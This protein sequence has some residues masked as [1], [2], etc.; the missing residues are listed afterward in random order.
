MGLPGATAYRSPRRWFN[1]QGVDI[2]RRM[3][4]NV[5]SGANRGILGVEH[6]TEALLWSNT[7]PQPSLIPVQG[8]DGLHRRG[9]N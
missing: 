3:E 5:V 1:A 2:M 8:S 6:I 7:L 9:Q 4:K